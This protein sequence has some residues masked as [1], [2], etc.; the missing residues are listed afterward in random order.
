MTDVVNIV[1][2]VCQDPGRLALPEQ[3]T[4]SQNIV[5]RWKMRPDNI[6]T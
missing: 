5:H 1:E 2:S 6:L 3:E 4:D